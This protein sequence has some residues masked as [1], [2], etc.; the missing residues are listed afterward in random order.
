[1][2]E[3]KLEQFEGPMDLLLHL[4]RTHKIDIYDIPIF[5]LTEQYI[6][7]LKAM[8]SLN[9]EIASE[10]IVMASELLY[11]KS[12][13]LLPAPPKE[14]ETQ[15]DDPRRELMQKLLDYQQYKELSGYLKQREPLGAYTFT[16]TGEK[17]KGLIRYTKLD[18]P[19]EQLVTALEELVM[20]IE[21]KLPP[22][23]GVFSGIVER[24]VVSVAL[25]GDKLLLTV[26]EKPGISLVDAFL[27][28][29]STRAQVA[30]TFMA[31]LDLMKEEK[32]KIT[33]QNDEFIIN[34]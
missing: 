24:E 14:E 11:I 12:K 15:E 13:M 3:L 25:M 26:K 10:F 8:E 27:A 6:S 29:C 17:I 1:M 18:L 16:K 9:M 32:L 5:T 22:D 20:R 30:A 33:Y 4:I 7:Y 2:I 31:L 23:K 34:R 19:K 28:I 21:T